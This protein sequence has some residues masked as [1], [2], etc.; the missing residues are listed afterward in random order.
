MKKYLQSFLVIV[1]LIGSG[2][3]VHQIQNVLDQNRKI[4]FVDKKPI[5]LPK[6]KVLKWLSMGY[7]GLISDWLWINCVIYYGRYAID[8]DNPYYLYAERQGTLEDELGKLKKPEAQES[9]KDSLLLI[10]DPL[11]KLLYR[12]ESKGL[13]NYIYP[14]IDR[15]TTL[16]PHFIQPYIFGGVYVLLDTGEIEHAI[17]LLKK[18]HQF[19]PE[20]WEFPLYLGWIYWM[21]RG[22]TKKSHAYL[23]EAIGKKECPAFVGYLLRSFSL[24]LHQTEVTKMYLKGMVNSTDNIDIKERIEKLLNEFENQERE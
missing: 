21:Y 24:N 2:I 4:Q 12:F 13:V 5:F 14:M 11:K 20:R 18:G 3:M 16:D 15:V 9:P 17:S 10:D 23:I 22:N 1:L 8:E 7:R 6:G 19:N